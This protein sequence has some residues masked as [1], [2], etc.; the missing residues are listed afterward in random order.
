MRYRA[1]VV[2]KEQAD[3]ASKPKNERNEIHETLMKTLLKEWSSNTPVAP[4]Y[5]PF[6][7]CDALYDYVL[8][9]AA[10]LKKHG[11]DV[12]KP[13]KALNELNKGRGYA[14]YAAIP[15]EDAK[16][17]AKRQKEY[18]AEKKRLI[19]N[20]LPIP[21]DLEEQFDAKEPKPS[22]KTKLY[23]YS[24]VNPNGMFDSYLYPIQHSFNEHLGDVE[25][26]KLINK[27]YG[28]AHD[29]LQIA[30]LSFGATFLPAVV[31]SSG[32]MFEAYFNDD[33]KSQG[34]DPEKIEKYLTNNFSRTDY[35]AVIECEA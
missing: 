14:F 6:I 9:N 16:A 2:I 31:F 20:D 27:N 8:R 28:T 4:Y 15:P 5:D 10:E 12:D 35:V 30:D 19:E 26:C 25:A 11:I 21:S 18:Q 32:D 33:D 3:A 13:A 23:G 22:K 7:D 24:F 34:G 29:I 1:L 17:R